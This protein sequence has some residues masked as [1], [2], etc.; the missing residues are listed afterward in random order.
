MIQ[1]RN[2]LKLWEINLQNSVYKHT[3]VLL[4]EVIKY[5][6]PV[7]GGIYVDGTVGGGGYSEAILTASAPDG[8][9]IAL[10]VD[11]AAIEASRIYLA[12]FGA[13]A[14]VRKGSYSDIA[15]VA[16]SCP[17]GV[18]GMVLDLGISSHQV[19]EPARGF[20]FSKDAPL[21]MRMDMMGEMTASDIVNEYSQEDIEKIF[22]D[23][24]EE[25]FS[26]KIAAFIV[27]RRKKQRL[28]TTFELANVCC[29][30]YPR[31]HERIHPATRVF[32]ALRIAVN[33]ELENLNNFLFEA[34]QFLK[35]NGRLVVVSYHSLEDRLVKNRFRELKGA[36][37]ILT[38]KPIVA[39]DE[40]AARNPRARSAK[41]RAITKA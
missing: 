35:K 12:R 26:K 41:L 11:D 14:S 23:Y 22:R 30:A 24:G 17:Q 34:P 20:S 13:R 21:D 27:E 8:R 9:V 29:A 5:L 38:K 3:P 6:N 1:R 33:G 28:K 18:D 7:S 31:R 25:R 32:Q 40:E 36:F 39:S 15:G 4:K 19:D 2:S 16:A 10:D 37:V